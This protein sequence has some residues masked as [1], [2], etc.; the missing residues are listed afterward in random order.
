LRRL[1][2]DDFREFREFVFVAVSFVELLCW[3]SLSLTVA[4]SGWAFSCFGFNS[5]GT[6][7]TIG[8]RQPTIERRYQIESTLNKEASMAR[9]EI[10]KKQ[11]KLN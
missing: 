11:M 1:D 9:R 6:R 7:T 2:D 3:V 4:G 10:M 5:N 8:A